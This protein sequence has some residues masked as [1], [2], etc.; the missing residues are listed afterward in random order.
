MNDQLSAQNRA[1]LDSFIKALTRLG[2]GLTIDDFRKEAMADAQRTRQRVKSFVCW[3]AAFFLLLVLI[4]FSI[5]LF[6]IKPHT[7][8][9]FL[10]LLWAFALGG[11]GAITNTFL[12]L[13]KMVP[14]ETLNTSDFFEVIGR[15]TLGCLFSTVLSITLF[16]EQIG[17]F[18]ESFTSPVSQSNTT[19]G[20]IALAP[21][22]LGYSIPLVLRLLD[23]AIQAIE[24]TVG[25]EDRRTSPSAARVTRQPN[26]RK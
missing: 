11:L 2:D 3:G 10:I 26:R 25:A 20:A 12:H 17:K 15:T 4:E 14:Q 5:P 16:P 13:L 6:V 22:L 8:L 18:I 24:L 23:K 9:V 21:F 1:K 7:Y 19:A